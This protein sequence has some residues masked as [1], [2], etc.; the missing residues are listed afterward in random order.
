M[1]MLPFAHN[2]R[3]LLSSS[4]LLPCRLP[5]IQCYQ[6]EMVGEEEGVGVWRFGGCSIINYHINKKLM[7]HLPPRSV[8]GVLIRGVHSRPRCLMLSLETA[9]TFTLDPQ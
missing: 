2:P 5:L 4:A 8:C 6:D 1:L 7:G 3:H 9:A